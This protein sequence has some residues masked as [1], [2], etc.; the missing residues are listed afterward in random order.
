VLDV[1]GSVGALALVLV[2]V[3][4]LLAVLVSWAGD[5]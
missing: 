3:A 4:G 2:L 1:L 5:R